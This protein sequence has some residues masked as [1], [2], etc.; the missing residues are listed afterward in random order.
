[1]L[2]AFLCYT[3]MYAVRKSFLA[4][5]YENLELNEMH[6]KTILIISQILG[7]MISKFLGIKFISE[8]KHKQRTGMLI[9]LIGFGL[10]MLYIFALVPTEWMPITLFFN[11][12]PLGMV[13]GVVLSYL[14]GRRNTELLTAALSTTFIFSTGLVKS[15]GVWLIQDFQV[16]EVLM[17]FTTS[18][19]FMPFFLLS[20]WM[21]SLAPS[22]SSMDQAMRTKRQPMDKH[23]R[24][25][26]LKHYGLGFSGLVLLYVLLTVLRDFRDNFMVEFWGELGYAEEPALITQTETPVALVVLLISGTMVL[27]RNNQKAFYTGMIL[28][29]ASG[30]GILVFTLLFER[31]Q[32][33]P[34][35]WMV[36]TGI[37]IYL[38]YI[39]YHCLIFERLLAFLRFSGTIGYLFYV[40]DAFGYASSVGILLVK[41]LLHFKS[42]WVEF[43]I[44]LNLSTSLGITLLAIISLWVIFVHYRKVSPIGSSMDTP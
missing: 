36:A 25:L 6:F 42:T 22:P 23:Q 13:F 21:L 19:L 27:I 8:L 38:P 29:A 14:E 3:G 2:A 28:T 24:K 9:G 20:I 41:E 31:A 35:F 12:L 33:S 32:I 15:T 26:F 5:Q 40:A 17:P 7:Y 37:C 34:V 18:M 10:A 4:G 44:R 39:L 1:M 43:F 16:S 11:G 30:L